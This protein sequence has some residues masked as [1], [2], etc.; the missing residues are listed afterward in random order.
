MVAQ[1]KPSVRKKLEK[2]DPYCVHCGREDELQVHHRRNRGIGGTKGKQAA[3]TNNFQNLLRVCAEYNFQMESDARVASRARGWGHKLSAWED[4]AHPVF[5]CVTFTWY[6][7]TTD[8]EKV[9][10]VFQDNPF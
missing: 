6:V 4:T 5:D 1:I 2:R 3:S 8:G 10:V 9:E 7:L